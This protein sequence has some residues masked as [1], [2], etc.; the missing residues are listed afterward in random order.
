M[1]AV[2]P[3]AKLRKSSKELRKDSNDEDTACH[4]DDDVK[5]VGN[6]GWA[7]VFQKILKT[8]KPKRKKTVVLSKTKKLCDVT[9]KETEEVPPF[10][11]EKVKD[12]LKTEDSD[13]ETEKPVVRPKVRRRDHVGIRVKPSVLDRERERLLQKIATKGVVQLFNAVRQQQ[14]EISKKLS[15][16]GPLDRKREQVLKSIDKRKFLDVL[17]GETKSIKVDNDVKTD[18]QS[19][20]KKEKADKIWNVL[21]DD[22]VM[23]AALKDWDRNEEDENSSAPEDMDSDD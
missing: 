11:I 20:T 6:P 3:T 12:E 9:K 21:R 22:F 8:K 17:M 2:E 14:G 23:G 7:D 13:E 19:D 4:E 15:D 18:E 1:I 16:A 5:T 10:E